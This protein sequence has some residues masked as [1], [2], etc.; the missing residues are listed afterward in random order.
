MLSGV[1]MADMRRTL[2]HILEYCS[3]H[4][5]LFVDGHVKFFEYFYAQDETAKYFIVKDGSS[6]GLTGVTAQRGCQVSV[7]LLNA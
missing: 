5:D 7:I 1:V 3:Q 4:P 2:D 6:F